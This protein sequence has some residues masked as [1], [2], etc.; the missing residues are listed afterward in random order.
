MAD[1]LCADKGEPAVRLEREYTASPEELWS[2]WTEPEQLARWLCASG[3]PLGTV[4]GPVR[5][6]MGDGDDEWV[7][8][9][10]VA[11]DPPHRLELTWSFPGTVNS[12][13]VVRI[14]RV[15]DSTS[16]VT[17]EHSGLGP[18]TGGYG[19]GWQAYLDRLTSHVDGTVPRSWDE[20]FEEHRSAAPADRQAASGHG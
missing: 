20:L 16:R 6:V 15:D 18:A 7:D 3:S 12:R 8:V 17:V 10:V 14:D 2:A 11:A 4:G 5:L 1:E 13:L 19:A 9:T